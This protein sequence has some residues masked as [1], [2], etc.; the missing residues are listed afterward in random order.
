MTLKKK[1]GLPDYYGGNLDA[2]WDCLTGWV[3]LP[4]TVEWRGYDESRLLVGECA[5]K[6]RDMLQ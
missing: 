3:G 1:L 4:M 2:S 5:E 6:P